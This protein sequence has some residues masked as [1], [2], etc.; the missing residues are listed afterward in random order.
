[1]FAQDFGDIPGLDVIFL[2]GGYF[3]HTAS[4]TVERLLNV[5][6]YF[7]NFASNCF[8][9]CLCCHKT[10]VFWSD[11]E[12]VFYTIFGISDVRTLFTCWDVDSKNALGKLPS[13][14]RSFCSEVV[15]SGI[16]LSILD[17]V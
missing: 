13:G 2:L 1:M 16:P 12:L 4:D 11:Y 15:K 7:C 8:S 6:S 5:M 14:S 17:I 10:A 3:Y 9:S